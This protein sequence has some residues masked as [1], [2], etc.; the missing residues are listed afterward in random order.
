MA[1]PYIGEIRLFGGTFAPAGWSFCNGATMSI[2]QNDALYNLIGTTYG[3]NGQTTFNLPDL[4]GRVPVHQ[5]QG[6]GLQNYV[7]GQK[8][9]AQTVTLTVAQL[10][11]HPHTAVGSASGAGTGSPANATWGNSGIGNES[12]GPGTSAS[13]TMNAAS[14]SF[15][16]GNQPHDNMLPFLAVSFIIALQGVYPS[17]S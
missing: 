17:P 15:T 5:G 10:P 7:L 3:G 13:Q 9:G 1:Q 12:F 14:T 6:A 16:G 11:S 4:Q 8:G 2:Q